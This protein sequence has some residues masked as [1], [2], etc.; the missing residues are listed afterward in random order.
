[1]PLGVVTWARARAFLSRPRCA[2]AAVLTTGVLL[3][4]SVPFGSTGCISFAWYSAFLA[5]G[6]LVFACGL[7]YDAI[8]IKET[9]AEAAAAPP[10]LAT[11]LTKRI[12]S[13]WVAFWILVFATLLCVPATLLY[14]RA[15]RSG[16]APGQQANRYGSAPAHDIW[17]GNAVFAISTAL[18]C[19][20]LGI[21]AADAYLTFE[22]LAAMQGHPVPE[23]AEAMVQLRLIWGGL[24][25]LTVGASLQVLVGRP[26]LGVSIIV[27]LLCGGALIT[28]TVGAVWLLMAQLREFRAHELDSKEDHPGEATQLLPAKRN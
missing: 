23:A 19:V 17:A 5:L 3:F 27:G 14:V 13:R 22:D 28:L 20:G 26:V 21:Q 15:A 25:A 1:M 9:E 4:W 2:Q 7:L 16:A 18:F 24:A 6:N 11:L 10:E 12:G 8:V